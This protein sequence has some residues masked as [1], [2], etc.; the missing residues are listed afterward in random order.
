M[1]DDAINAQDSLVSAVNLIK[2]SDIPLRFEAATL[3]LNNPDLFALYGQLQYLLQIGVLNALKQEEIAKAIGLSL[4]T[5]IAR[6]NELRGLGLIDIERSGKN[7]TIYFMPIDRIGKFK[8][9]LEREKRLAYVEKLK[10]RIVVVSPEFVQKQ[11]DIY[12][13]KEKQKKIEALVKE[14]V[15]KEKQKEKA[16]QQ[17]ED[18]KFPEEDYEIVIRNYKKYKGVGLIGPDFLR[19][20]KAVKQMFKSGHKPK[21]IVDCMIFFKSKQN[22][23]NYK[24]L[25]MWTIETVMKKMAEFK[26]GALRLPEMGDDLPNL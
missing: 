9:P 18:V 23:E 21:E 20:K 19:A 6:R 16:R 4:P 1:N 13:E 7:Y 12:R 2:D 8:M 11:A 5:Y 22:D 26:A 25:Q 15:K 17:R 24:W 3:L 10:E 14:Q